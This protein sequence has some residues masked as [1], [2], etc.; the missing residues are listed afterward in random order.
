MAQKAVTQKILKNVVIARRPG[1]REGLTF[2]FAGQLMEPMS[3]KQLKLYADGEFEPEPVTEPIDMELEVPP[4]NFAMLKLLKPQIELLSANPDP[5]QLGVFI[6]VL[7][8]ALTR[9]YRGVPRWL[10]EQSLDVANMPE[11]TQAFM[12]VSGLKRKEREDAKKAMASPSTGMG[13]TPT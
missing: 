12:D 11:L 4:L 8:L 13:S 3:A 1:F 2:R 6:E 10:I 9:N 5:S 7:A